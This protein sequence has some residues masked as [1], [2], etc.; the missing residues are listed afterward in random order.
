MTTST[1]VAVA[2][3]FFIFAVVQFDTSG[4]PF[5]YLLNGTDQ[6]VIITLLNTTN[7]RLGASP[8]FPTITNNVGLDAPHIIGG[9]WNGASSVF[10]LDGTTSA[11]SVGTVA[12]SLLTIGAAGASLATANAW[13]D[14]FVAE[15]II[16][17]RSLTASEIAATETY[18]NTKWG[19]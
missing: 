9:L 7:L 2:Q 1:A 6:Q 15:I 11:Q 14:G 12:L 16:V 19:L 8:T 4:R 13:L 17:G 5:P 3:P 18:L 10:R